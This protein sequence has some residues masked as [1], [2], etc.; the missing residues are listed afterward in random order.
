MLQTGYLFTVQKSQRN[1]RQKEA[2]RDGVSRRTWKK[3]GSYLLARCPAVNS[4]QTGSS[5]SEEIAAKDGRYLL[6]ASGMNVR[7]VRVA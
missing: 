2:V 7:V 3:H 1:Q 6:I 5:L 4:Y